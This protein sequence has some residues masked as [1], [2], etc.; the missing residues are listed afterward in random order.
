MI[1]YLVCSIFD[2]DGQK[3]FRFYTPIVGAK[4]RLSANYPRRTTTK[5]P[6]FPFLSDTTGTS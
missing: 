4:K 2:N 1:S 3:S 5:A 6:M